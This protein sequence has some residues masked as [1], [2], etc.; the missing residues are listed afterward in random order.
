MIP[1]RIALAFFLLTA[2]AGAWGCKPS[3]STPEAEALEVTIYTSVDQ[4]I[5]EPILQD[6]QKRTG[7]TVRIITDT[8]ATKSAGLAARLLAEQRDPRADVW[9]GNEVFHTINLAHQGVLAAYDS[10]AAAGIPAIYRDKQNRWAGTCLRA[11]V[12]ATASSVSASPPPA[13]ATSIEALTDPALRGRIGIASPVAGTTG[14]HVAA[15]YAL[16]GRNR[17]DAYFRALHANEAR[18][19]G[20][21]SVVAAGVA[22]GTLLAGLTDNDDVEAAARAGGS[23]VMRLPDQGADGIG[24]LTIPCTVGVV[25]DAKHPSAARKLVDFL[26]SEEVERRLIEARFGQYSVRSEQSAAVKTMAIRYEDAAELLPWATTR[27]RALLEGREP[28]KE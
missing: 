2:Y 17:A 21:N 22:D 4:P 24:T 15:L 16:W 14:G 11:R 7:I 9:W 26:L 1:T 12:I 13:W 20:G 28:E 3:A 5:A 25:A 10:P 18:V 6:F 23:I 19:L 27:A 8:E